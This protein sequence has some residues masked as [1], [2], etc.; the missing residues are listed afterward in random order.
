MVTLGEYHVSLW[1]APYQPAWA[2]LVT[3]ALQARYPQSNVIKTNRAAGGSTVQW[4][5]EHAA[6]LVPPC[7]PDLIMLGFG[8]NSMQ[9]NEDE[10]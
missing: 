5:V 1:H 9:E 3:N 2:E 6:E 10:Q 8:M 4:G 7:K